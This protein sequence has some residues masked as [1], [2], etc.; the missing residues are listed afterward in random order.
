VS[1]VCSTHGR[2]NKLIQSFGGKMKDPIERRRHGKN[3]IKM[4]LK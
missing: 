3:N 2:E 4:D 1:W